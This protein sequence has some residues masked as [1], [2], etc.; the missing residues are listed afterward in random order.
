MT[1]FIINNIIKVC[2]VD[3]LKAIG[4]NTDIDDSTRLI[5]QNAVVDSIGLVNIIVD[6][7]TRLMD[8]GYDVTIVS[9][10]AISDCKSP[11][12]DVESMTEFIFNEINE[13]TLK[14]LFCHSCEGRN[15]VQ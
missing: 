14:T 10:H 2:I 6:I 3:Y 9:E 13:A 15:P 7:E 8:E 11:F 12:K 4:K 5:G 1:R